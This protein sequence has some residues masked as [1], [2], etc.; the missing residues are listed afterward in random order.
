MKKNSSYNCLTKQKIFTDDYAIVPIRFEDRMDIL[1]WR[2]EQL[3]HLRQ[4]KLLTIEDQENY[5]STIVA[6]LFKQEFPNQL[7]FSYLK[8]DLCIGYGGLVHINWIDKN[9]ELSFIMN[10]ELEKENFQFH[11]KT[12][13]E[14]IEELAFHELN[15][16]KIFTYAFDLRPNLF[17][18]LKKAGFVEESRLREHCL[19]ENKFIDVLIHSKL[20]HLIKLRIASIKDLRV[21]FNWASSKLVRQYSFQKKNISFTSH[22]DWFS[23]KLISKDCV[24]MIAELNKTPIGS[25]RFDINKT[26]D[27]LISFLLDPLS[28]GKG[29]GKQLLE[30][31]CDEVVKLKKI[32]NIIGKV[33]IENTPS[34]NIFKNLGF[35]KKSELDSYITFIKKIDL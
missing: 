14:L 13:L 26:G 24:Y 20:N 2:N 29:L 23:K 18:V 1:K 16:H 34:L 7:L 27:A 30:I 25:I 4:A 3:Y 22:E 31:G 9:A 5:F 19:F 21:T 10:T 28:H 6:Q 12:F 8:D 17:T 11:W 35:S 32:N 15:F 33:N